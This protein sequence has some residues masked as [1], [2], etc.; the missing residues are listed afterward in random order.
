MTTTTRPTPDLFAR[1]FTAANGGAK[2]L[3]SVR[4]HVRDRRRNAAAPGTV[5]WLMGT[6]GGPYT[7][8]GAYPLFWLTSDGATLSYRAVLD[9]LMQ[10]A[11]AVRDDSNCGWRVVACDVNYE[12]PDMYCEHSGDRIESAYAEDQAASETDTDS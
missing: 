7:S 5:A 11:R 10:I 3:Y 9:N 2:D 12:D 6:L 8:H 1:R 4:Q